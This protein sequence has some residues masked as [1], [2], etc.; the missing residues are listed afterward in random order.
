M[1]SR[2]S[3]KLR[4]WMAIGAV[5]GVTGV[6]VFALYQPDYPSQLGCRLGYAVACTRLQIA[7]VTR[8]V[9]LFVGAAGYIVVII[10]AA[11]GA[12][13]ANKPAPPPH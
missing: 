13:A 3:P 11:L 6:L 7:L 5:A 8:Y 10:C 2:Y 1:R 9:A 12:T 4:R